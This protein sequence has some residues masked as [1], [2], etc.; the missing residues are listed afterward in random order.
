MAQLMS[1]D[2]VPGAA[3]VRTDSPPVGKTVLDAV[4]GGV[5]SVAKYTETD[6]ANAQ[7]SHFEQVNAYRKTVTMATDFIVRRYHLVTD[8]QGLMI[9]DARAVEMVV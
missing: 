3:A 4:Q 6:L 8:F 1:Q 7:R 2:Q 5:G 9:T